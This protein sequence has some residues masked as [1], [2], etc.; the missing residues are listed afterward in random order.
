MG[1]I[2]ALSSRGFLRELLSSLPE[3]ELFSPETTFVFPTR[4]AAL[5]FRHYLFEKRQKAGFLPRILSFA[6]LVGELASALDPSPLL[7]RA[8]QAWL[9][10]EIVRERPPFAKV[11]T[12]FDR[13]FPWGLRLAEVLDQ[14]EREL[15]EAQNIVY[16]PEEELPEEARLFLEHLGEIQRNFRETLKARG[17]TTSGIRLRLL[18]TQKEKLPFPQGPLHLVGFFMLTRAEQ[19]L[20][21]YWLKQGATL[22][23]RLEGEE[24]PEVY[25]RLEK[26]F[27]LRAERPAPQTRRPA[28]H[29]FEAPDVHHE[30]SKLRELLPR[31]IERPDETLI[32]LCAAGHLIPLLYELPEGITVNI[33]LGYPLF[34]TPL[35]QLFLLFTEVVESSHGGEIHIPAYLKLLKHPYL[36]GLT[37][38]GELASI[39]FRN[40]ENRLRDHGSPFLTL[41]QIE[42]LFEGDELFS[43]R[44]RKFLSWFHRRLLAP[45]LR[46]QTAQDLALC[47]RRLVKECTRGRLTKEEDTEALLE[48]AFIYAFETEV[49]PS[50]ENVSFAKEKLAA[51]T[52]F[53]FLKELLRNIRA[54]FEGEP[55]EGLQIMGLLETRLLSFRQ[56]F[57]L[58]ANE[59]YLPSVEEVNPLLPE[60]IKPLLGL[61]PREREE[62]IERH[63]FF[64]LVYGAEEV[65][66]FYQSAVSGKGE[67]AGK[68]LRSRYVE[69]LLW[70]EEKA[71]GKLLPEKISF[72]PLRLNP[73]AFKRQEA[74]PKGEAEKEAVL[75]LLNRE[76]GLSATLIN[77]YLACPAKF[78]FHYLLGLRPTKEVAEFDAAELGNIVHAALEEYF[79]PFIGRTY[80]PLED[81]DPQRLLGFFEE[82]FRLSGLYHRLG[83]ERRFFVEETARFRL[84]R[85]LEFLARHHV[86]GFEILSLEKEYHRNFQ[87]LHFAGRIDRLE[88]RGEKLYVLDYKTGTFVKT[89]SSKHL[90]EKL[91][92][93]DPPPSFGAEEFFELRERLPDIQLFLYLFLTTEEGTHNAAYLQLAAGKFRDL[94]KPL[95]YEKYLSLEKAEEFMAVRF[96]R[97][98]EYLLRHM[99]EAEAFYATPEDKLCSFCDFRLACECS[100]KS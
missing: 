43:L 35:S 39:F 45:W 14:L 71:K 27:G 83:P 93:Y 13:F 29:F 79:R 67:S 88:R 16:P 65:F 100:K 37:F 24:F 19:E 92:P 87:G 48:R 68:K 70:E 15:V 57:V 60:G 32:L 46:I 95:F 72:V 56:I 47:L 85:Y 1:R 11:A 26:I 98:L 69:R 89:Y 73:K 77:T 21:K 6:D 64:A 44:A 63:H 99:V 54:P 40:L 50:L 38:E 8:D 74:I 4:R 90:E 22:W 58:D 2:R 33:T 36:R 23:W 7:P 52:L 82:F 42:A 96:P 53:T 80:F 30:L 59:G 75:K 49:L 17:L 55:L 51:K 12:S 41:E 94:E 86:E 66:L 76:T 3:E 62:I 78:Y 18:A 20:F 9:L 34:R 61:P 31:K 91:F 97:L 81:N 10:W 25:H 84:R 5:Y 28:L